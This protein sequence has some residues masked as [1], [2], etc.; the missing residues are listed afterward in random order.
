MQISNSYIDL[1]EKIKLSLQNANIFFSESYERNSIE[2]GQHLLYLWS[3]YHVLVARIKQKFFLKAAVLESEPFVLKE[4][5]EEKY[6]LNV[7]MM[8]LKNQGIQWAVVANTARSK[9]THQ[10][11]MWFRVVIIS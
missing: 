3:E 1:P 11:V 6:F 8:G 2:R 9:H 4:G 5:E 10:V 7:A